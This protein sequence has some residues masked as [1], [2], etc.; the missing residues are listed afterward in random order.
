MPPV[1]SFAAELENIEQPV[2]SRRYFA[3]NSSTKPVER[4]TQKSGRGVT[5]LIIY[6]IIEGSKKQTVVQRV[7]K[8]VKTFKTSHGHI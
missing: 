1:V 4:S 5:T 8:I 2:L 6:P 7:G 3:L